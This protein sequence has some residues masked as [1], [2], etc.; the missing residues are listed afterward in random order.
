MSRTR[1]NNGCRPTEASGFSLIEIMIALAVFAL[2]VRLG[3]PSYHD[4]I[5]AQQLAN[6]AHFIADTLDL[7]RSEAIKHGYRVNLCKTHDQRQ[8]TD[9]GGW[10]QGWLLF[11]DENDSGQVDDD[12][13]VLHREGPARDSITM[14]GNRPVADYVSYTSLGHAR[15]RSGA[16]QM[17]T[18]TLCKPGQNALKVVLANSGR[19]RIDRTTDR[20]S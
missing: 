13:S 9:D 16:L 7:A 11:V 18:F 5:A 8:C 3:L 12:E 19:A 17:G 14:R 6:H 10:E 4:W 1:F 2:L 20:C 15:L